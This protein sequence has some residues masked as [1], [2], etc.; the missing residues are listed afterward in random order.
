ML[1]LLAQ[2]AF[3]FLRIGVIQ[4]DAS[5]P[6]RLIHLFGH[7]S[8]IMVT[9]LILRVEHLEGGV[10]YQVVLLRSGVIIFDLSRQLLLLNLLSHFKT[11]IVS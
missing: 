8:V 11:T 5:R 10:V 6:L 3:G 7:V 4:T 1:K 2:V 9:D